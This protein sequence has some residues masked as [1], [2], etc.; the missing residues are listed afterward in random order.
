[1]S[2]YFCNH[3]VSQWG[4]LKELLRLHPLPEFQ[5]FSSVVDRLISG[6]P[7]AYEAVIEHDDRLVDLYDQI[8]RKLYEHL[9]SIVDA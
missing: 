2:Q 6:A 3:E 7:D 8:Q 1:M 9:L 5:E 4:Q